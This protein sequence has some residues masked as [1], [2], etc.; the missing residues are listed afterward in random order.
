[1][2]KIIDIKNNRKEISECLTRILVVTWK[3]LN[4]NCRERNRRQLC[5]KSRLNDTHL[6]WFLSAP[7]WNDPLD[8]TSSQS[9]KFHLSLSARIRMYNSLGLIGNFY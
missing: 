8:T 6:V 1:M 7:V 5:A 9:L 4:D 2:I 3:Y